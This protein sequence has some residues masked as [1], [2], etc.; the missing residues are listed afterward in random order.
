VVAAEVTKALRG[1]AH[2]VAGAHDFQELVDAG[3]QP[4]VLHGDAEAAAA[5]L[6][7]PTGGG[8]SEAL[9]VLVPADHPRL[10]GVVRGGHLRT[11]ERSYGITS[12]MTKTM[13]MKNNIV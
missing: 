5:V 4:R 12:D 9:V 3:V 6:A 2:L 13:T 11:V 8:A 10:R 1:H 7:P